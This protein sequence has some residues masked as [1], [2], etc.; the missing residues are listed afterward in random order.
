V[1]ALTGARVTEALSSKLSDV[2]FEED[3]DGCKWI[4]IYFTEHKVKKG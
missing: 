3:D 1:I 2:K 4:N